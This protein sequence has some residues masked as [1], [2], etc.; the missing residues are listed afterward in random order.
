M[1][2]NRETNSNTRTQHKDTELPHLPSPTTAPPPI[3]VDNQANYSNL[4]LFAPPTPIQSYLQPTTRFR[5]DA[6]L[7][8]KDKA[9]ID[10]EDLNI[11][12]RPIC[13]IGVKKKTH[14]LCAFIEPAPEGSLITKLPGFDGQFLSKHYS[15]YVTIDEHEAKHLFYYFVE[16]ERNP[17]EDPVVLWLGGGPGCSALGAFIYQHGRDSGLKPAINLKELLEF[18]GEN[19]Q[20][21]HP[22]KECDT[23]LLKF[24]SALFGIDIY[25]ILA[26]CSDVDY[27]SEYRCQDCIDEDGFIVKNGELGRSAIMSVHDHRRNETSSNDSQVATNISSLCNKE[28][29]GFF[30]LNNDGVRKS[31]HAA[32]E[33]V[34]GRWQICSRKIT[35]K[36]DGGGM[37]S[38]HKRLIS[39]GLRVL[40]YSGDHDLKVPYI[41]SEAWTRSLSYKI[42]D[43][44]R[45]WISGAQ[46]AGYAQEY[47]KNLT[48][49]TV[50]GA[51][52]S[53][54]EDK[55]RE[56]FD[57]Y[58]RWI[59]GKRV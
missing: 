31:I 28:M 50:K 30:W 4:Q 41:G 25:D 48:F 39:L 47:D 15:G 56:T 13:V 18:C 34:T 35:Y 42:I 29:V 32:E 36:K 37:I 16:S 20:V 53:A 44:W 52:H 45:P 27:E 26:P 8:V 58:K 54:V 24:N 59:S 57:F 19:F 46:V 3:P 43:E 38:Y 5:H 22:G 33:H 40:I 23:R 14:S 49:L 9:K 1:Q 51:G 10:M 6:I 12:T 55:P 17:S 21:P 7:D 2:N 11:E